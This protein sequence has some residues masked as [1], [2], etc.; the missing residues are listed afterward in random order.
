MCLGNRIKPPM[1]CQ[2]ITAIPLAIIVMK[3]HIFVYSHVKFNIKPAD[4]FTA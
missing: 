4:Y 3:H 2:K 1:A